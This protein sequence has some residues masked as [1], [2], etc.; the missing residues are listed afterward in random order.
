MRK[1]LTYTLVLALGGLIAAGIA[2]LTGLVDPVAETP[3]FLIIWALW[4]WIGWR[5]ANVK[6]TFRE[7][8][9]ATSDFSDVAAALSDVVEENRRQ[10]ES[11]GERLKAI[12]REIAD[13]I[14]EA[15][16][17]YDEHGK[18]FLHPDLARELDK[19]GNEGLSEI[20]AMGFRKIAQS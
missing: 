5:Y 20:L 17:Y 6:D 12:I 7:P 9:D 11:D 14:G 19:P 4:L 1:V 18:V 8:K 15:A 10:I 16:F 2:K 3:V 13:R